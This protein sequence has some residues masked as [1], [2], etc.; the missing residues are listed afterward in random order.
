MLLMLLCFD[1]TTKGEDDVQFAVYGILQ[2][3]GSMD[4]RKSLMDK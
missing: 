4:L 3:K 1:F 2:S